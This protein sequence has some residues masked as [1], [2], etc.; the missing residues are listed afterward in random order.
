MIDVVLQFLDQ[1][2]PERTELTVHVVDVAGNPIPDAQVRVVEE[3]DLHSV[4]SYT[5][6]W[7]ASEV[8]LEASEL[9]FARGTTVHLVVASPRHKAQVMEWTSSGSKR[10]ALSVSL[11]PIEFRDFAGGPSFD[12][13]LDNFEHVL[14]P[15]T[16]PIALLSSFGRSIATQTPKLEDV[17]AWTNLALAETAATYSGHEFV[18]RTWRL[19]GIRA[20]AANR[21]LARILRDPTTTPGRDPGV[22]AQQSQRQAGRLARAWGEYALASNTDARLA[23]DLCTSATANPMACPVAD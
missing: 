5:G 6:D 3:G 12:Y 19:H 10:D 15:G 14:A 2:T 23:I 16:A 4:N 11:R 17:L 18:E 13:S 8:Y 9:A 7:T 22:A 1:L 20:V 21:E